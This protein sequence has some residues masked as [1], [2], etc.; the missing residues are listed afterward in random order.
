MNSK[1]SARLPKNNPFVFCWVY[2]VFELHKTFTSR[3]FFLNE[4]RIGEL[5][6]MNRRMRVKTAD[7]SPALF[8]RENTYLL[9][10]LN[11]DNVPQLAQYDDIYFDFSN[12]Q[13]KLLKILSKWLQFA[14][15]LVLASKPY[16]TKANSP[17]RTHPLDR[18]CFKNST[19]AFVASLFADST[20]TFTL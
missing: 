6:T 5:Q 16:E 20:T 18:F 19:A 15:T 14:K 9:N 17:A 7:R 1:K 11:F 2:R 3:L 4:Y 12:D 10:K 13:I 8:L